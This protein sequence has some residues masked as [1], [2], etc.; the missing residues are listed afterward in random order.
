MA[1]ILLVS[2][3]L[4]ARV[5]LQAAIAPHEVVVRRPDQDLGDLLPATVVLDLDQLGAEGTARWADELSQLDGVR[6]LGF[7]SH[8]DAELGRAASALGIETIRRGRFWTTV[9]EILALP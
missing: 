4:Q 8:V 6:L 3:D 7:F 5:R 1:Q 9:A 2:T